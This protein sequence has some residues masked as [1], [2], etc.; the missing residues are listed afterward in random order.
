MHSALCC[1]ALAS[2]QRRNPIPI[3]PHFL[4]SINWLPFPILLERFRVS[5]CHACPDYRSG[6]HSIKSRFFCSVASVLLRVQ[7]ACAHATLR[8]CSFVLSKTKKLCSIALL[9][10][11]NSMYHPKKKPSIISRK[12]GIAAEK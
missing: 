2:I 5:F 7:L 4:F 10:E 8:K 12:T 9:N 1:A 11:K 3:S 6:V